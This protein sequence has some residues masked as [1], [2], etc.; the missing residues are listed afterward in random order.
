MS[1]HH[2]ITTSRRH[3]VSGGRGVRAR[4]TAG[5]S[6]E[7]KTSAPPDGAALRTDSDAPSPP[8]DATT[9]RR[10]D[11]TRATRTG[12]PH[13]DPTLD[14]VDSGDGDP[15]NRAPEEGPLGDGVAGLAAQVVQMTLVSAAPLERRLGGE[16]DGGEKGG[17]GNAGPHVRSPSWAGPPGWLPRWPPLG[18]T[19]RTSLQRSAPQCG[20]RR[21]SS[22]QRPPQRRPRRR[23][24]RTLR[25]QAGRQSPKQARPPPERR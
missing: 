19:K 10:H 16:K 9:P 22:L 20:A 12:R 25:P 21:R 3:D 4:S 15:G 18:C 6:T 7:P 8:S 11:A 23:I 14:G 5:G 17:G 1:R 2:D 24:H 13:G